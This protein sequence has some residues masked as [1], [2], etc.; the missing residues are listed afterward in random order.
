MLH[1]PAAPAQDN[2]C[3]WMLLSEGRI[4]RRVLFN[5]RS[6]FGALAIAGFRFFDRSTGGT[7]GTSKVA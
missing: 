7:L 2:I 1:R 6:V 4:A 5:V 3:R